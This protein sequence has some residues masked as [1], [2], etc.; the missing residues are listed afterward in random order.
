M[1]LIYSLGIRIYYVGILCASLFNKKA[2]LWIKGRRKLLEK[3][4]KTINPNNNT[5]WIHTAS[6]GEFEQGRPVIEAIKKISNN[7]KILITFFS[8]SGYEIRKNYQG[9]D[10]I[11]YLPLD[12]KSNAKKFISIVQPKKVFFI[13]YEFWYHYLKVLHDRNI[14]IFLLSGIFRKNQIFFKWYGIWFKKILGNFS[15]IFLQNKGSYDLLKSLH[16]N[17]ISVSGDTRFDR[18]Y[19]IAKQAKTIETV[20]K[21]CENSLVIICGSTWEKDEQLLLKF[22]NQ[23]NY[24]VKYIIAPHEIHDSHI[25]QLLSGL[26]KPVV[27]FSNADKCQ[28]NDKKILVIDNIG[29]LSSLYKYGDIAYIGGGFGVGIHNILEAA[30]FGLPIL[31]G[32]N[33]KKFN[34]A[35]DLIKLQGAFC[36]KSFFELKKKLEWLIS[37]KEYRYKSGEIASK[38]IK[39]NKGVTPSILKITFP[40]KF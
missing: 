35:V 11:F 21:F 26:E 23:T 19:D 1:R 17:N 28:I 12:T 15:H 37:N 4:A 39:D 18:V 9:A 38:Y 20:K 31:F 8:P 27:C 34:E 30:T 10:Y 6:L 7:Y 22:I 13:K 5:I 3:I 40:E 14:P 33:Y 32:P 24:S 29:M 2:K 25:Q 36:I 16:L